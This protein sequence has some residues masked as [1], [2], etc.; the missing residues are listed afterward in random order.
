MMTNELQALRQSIGERL[1]A[2]IDTPL[3]GACQ[4]TPMPKELHTL[5]QDKLTAEAE[6]EAAR[7]RSSEAYQV[8]AN[9]RAIEKQAIARFETARLAWIEAAEAHYGA[10][11]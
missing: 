2:A 5:R 7:K 4:D 8:L 10:A 3:L 9:A 6:M 1:R 11:E